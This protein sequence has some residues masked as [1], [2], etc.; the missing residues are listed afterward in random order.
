MADVEWHPLPALWP[1]PAVWTDVGGSLVFH[2][3][4]C[5]SNGDQRGAKARNSRTMWSPKAL[6]AH[7]R[8]QGQPHSSKQKRSPQNE[9]HRHPAG[10]GEVHPCPARS[11]TFL[12][13]I[14]KILTH[15][16]AY[17]KFGSPR[18]RAS[19]ARPLRIPPGASSAEARGVIR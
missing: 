3:E 6:P 9:A 16:R 2:V 19:R 8:W 5:A 14:Y 18:K 17:G 4:R 15:N 1:E 7:P 11:V 12:S 13:V 10:P